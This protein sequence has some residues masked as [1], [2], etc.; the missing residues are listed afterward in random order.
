MKSIDINCD[1]GEGMAHDEWIMPYITSANIACGYHAGDEQ[2]MRQTVALCLKYGVS[3]GAH[4]SFPDRENFGRREMQLPLGEVYNLIINQIIAIE[5]ILLEAGATIRH[6]KPH[7]ALYNMAAKDS[8]LA[9]AIAQ[10][11]KDFNPKLVLFGLC[12]SHLIR[13]GE[14][15]GLKTAGEAFADRTYQDDGSL[16]PRK[17]PGALIEDPE[18]AVAQVLEMIEEGRVTTV[19][20]K[21]IS[22]APDTICL[23]GDG[24]NAVAL[25]KAIH[26]ALTAKGALR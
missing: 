3:I 21:K 11:V 23:H 13:E 1:L 24:T 19:S 18:K 25:A 6:V 26:K 14:A 5:K 8:S 9:A 7:G 22:I 17:M 12:N 16:T 2:T 4:P 20:G 10:A 15:L